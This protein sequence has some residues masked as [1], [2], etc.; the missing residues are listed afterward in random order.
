MDTS[1]SGDLKC[2]VACG[3][4]GGTETC[5]HYCQ[6]APVTGHDVRFPAKIRAMAIE[7]DIEV[8]I[9]YDGMKISV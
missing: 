3:L 7:R 6:T 2:A 4:N 8:R 9:A 5:Q 1:A